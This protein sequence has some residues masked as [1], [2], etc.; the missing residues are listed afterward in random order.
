MSI[1]GFGL[2]SMERGV[3]IKDIDRMHKKFESMPKVKDFQELELMY[4]QN[5]MLS[6]AYRS[7][8]NNLLFFMQRCFN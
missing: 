3:G 2:P 7:M 6:I 5:C 4:V 1:S 8:H